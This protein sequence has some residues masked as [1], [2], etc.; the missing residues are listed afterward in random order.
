MA[1]IDECIGD[2]HVLATGSGEDDDLGNVVWGQGVAASG[3]VVSGF[4]GWWAGEI[5]SSTYAYT[6]SA[7]AL[8]PLNL[9]REKS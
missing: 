4:T 6:A 5:E 2:D 3:K 8:S 7:L 1:G 9:K